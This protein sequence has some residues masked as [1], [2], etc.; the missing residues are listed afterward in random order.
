MKKLTKLLLMNWHYISHEMIEFGDINFLTGGN[1]SG[2]STIMDA[3]QLL[4]LCDTTGNF[5]N[6]A[7]NEKSTRTLE[8]YLRGETG[9]QVDGEAKY[10]R[11][12]AF[13]SYICAEFWNENTQKPFVM[14]VCFDFYSV[15]DR[16]HVFFWLDDA[17]Q[18]RSF[19]EE[20]NLPYSISVLRSHL[21]GYSETQK[22]VSGSNEDFRK[23][24]YGKLGNFDM[25]RFAMLLKQAVQFKP[26]EKIQDFIST[27]ALESKARVDISSMQENIRHYSELE[28]EAGK[29]ETQMKKLEEIN[30]AYEQYRLQM[31]KK[32]MYDFMI[33]YAQW[34]DNQDEA[35]ALENSL[36]MIRHEQSALL[37]ALLA[38]GQDKQRMQA[39]LEQKQQLLYSDSDNRQA[40]ELDKELEAIKVK[41]QQLQL[42]LEGNTN[43]LQKLLSDWK[44][45]LER[46]ADHTKESPVMQD[47]L[48][49]ERFLTLC[50]STQQ[51]LLNADLL[52]NTCTTP[53]GI[54]QSHVQL[55]ALCEGAQQIH[56]TS[57]AL[58]DQQKT[59][60]RAL[61]TQHM[62]NQTEIQQ[63]ERG[64]FPFPDNVRRLQQAI[65]ERLTQQ[66]PLDEHARAVVLA[67][68]L[69]IPLPRWRNA[70]EGYLHTQKFYLIVPPKCYPTARDLYDKVKEEMNLFG[71]AVVNMTKLMN[72]RPKV[73]KQSLS[74]E[75]TTTHPYARVFADYLLGRVMKCDHAAQLSGFSAAIT[76][77]CMLYQGHALRRLN[78]ESWKRPAIGSQ[79]ILE[80]KKQLMAENS[81]LQSKLVE[82]SALRDKLKALALPAIPTFVECK[83]FEEAAQRDA[84]LPLLQTE[85]QNKQKM[86]DAL[87]TTKAETLKQ[88][89]AQLT[90]D[91]HEKDGLMAQK[92]QHN[93][94]LEHRLA[95]VLEQQEKNQ[96]EQAACLESLQLKYTEQWQ[97]AQGIPRYVQEQN[98]GTSAKDIRNHFRNIQTS[99]TRSC[100]LLFQT[101]RDLRRAYSTSYSLGYDVDAVENTAFENAWLELSVNQLPA[102]TEKI[103][104]ARGKAYQ[105][106]QE[107]LISKL[108]SQI[109]AARR[110]IQRLN[111]AIRTNFG[112]DTYRFM[113]SPN[114][115]ERALYDMIM[116][117]IL[118]S[119]YNNNA[120]RFNEKYKQELKNLF[121][122][123]SD[124][125]LPDPLERRIERYTNYQTYVAFDMEVEDQQ[126]RKQQLS[127]TLRKK[128]GGETQTP[129]YIAV[130]ASFAQLYRIN[131]DKRDATI[132]LILFDE[133][134]SKM[135]ADRIIKSIELLKRFHF[136]VIL[137]A[138]P[139]KI[140]DISLLADRTLMVIKDN[141]HMFVRPWSPREAINDA[142]Q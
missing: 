134:F 67:Q 136:Q 27:F 109:E 18:P 83:R 135:D 4:L 85:L 123:I 111:D 63:L 20:N 9:E 121:I 16:K 38:D 15:G 46:F 113:M 129:F 17:L 54:L 117:D 12:N 5:F 122:Q 50:H 21:R 137:S 71:A 90:V 48:S 13:T 23:F 99:T 133:A 6:K 106:F 88:E 19:L 65:N 39:C 25:A 75:V 125:T 76:D 114:P 127:K 40:Q 118:M 141:Q 36:A 34:K 80:R 116:D 93:G 64:I 138:P 78:P 45:V 94:A 120:E 30:Q 37:A 130:L 7:A 31:E 61:Q 51:S 128:S 35:E 44:Q 24:I 55:A 70:I 91:I 56:D 96:T 28:E 43:Q 32:Q 66:F 81:E 22:Y 10:L 126:G 112:Q 84:E 69:E 8:G 89:I 77:Q 53:M 41:H 132:H 103:Q 1:G 97:E 119:G 92:Q 79:A 59:Y 3:L 2:K 72:D 73:D 105:Q 62:D 14:G 139:D 47:A 33:D 108:R 68:V 95:M 26:I 11:N 115:D 100:D 52:M 98:K 102:Y 87:D 142:E 86:R 82:A 131:Q 107:D 29:L 124:T 110:Q 60:C 140:M 42:L 49:T 101:L 104:M 57:V 58:A 74:A